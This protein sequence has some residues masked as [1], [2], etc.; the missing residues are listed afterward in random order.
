MKKRKNNFLIFLFST[1]PQEIKR[2]FLRQPF[3]LFW[4]RL[5]IRKDEFHKSL[6]FNPKAYSN[7]TTQEKREYN[8]DL[9]R[10]RTIAHKRDFKRQL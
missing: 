6:D 2:F 10:R 9:G 4:N 3:K 7:M 5:W 1:I 8:I